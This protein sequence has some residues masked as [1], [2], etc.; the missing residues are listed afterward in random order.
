MLKTHIDILNDF[1]PSVAKKWQELRCKDHFIIFKD[2]K[3]ANTGNT[4]QLQYIGGPFKIVEWVD[5]INAHSIASPGTTSALKNSSNF[6][7]ALLLLA[8]IS[9]LGT[10]A[11]ETYIEATI[12]MAEQHDGFVIGFICLKKISHD[13]K[14]IY[15]TPGIQLDTDKDRLGQTYQSMQQLKQEVM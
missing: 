9:S 15:F 14:W 12:K 6:H 1:H 8:E 13:P 3:F 5:V 10:L 11:K 7:K 4:V 2:R